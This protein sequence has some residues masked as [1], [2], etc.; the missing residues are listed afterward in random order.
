MGGWLA[1]S[2][3]EVWMVDGG[4]LALSVASAFAERSRSVDGELFIIRRVGN[5]HQL[6]FQLVD[7]MEINF[8]DRNCIRVLKLSIHQ[9]D[10]IVT[11][12]TQK[13]ASK[14][15]SQF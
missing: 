1:L 11:I 10:R 15:G 3:A 7:S 8:N 2:V 9:F 4:R 5:A 6:G 13:L 14:I 12:H